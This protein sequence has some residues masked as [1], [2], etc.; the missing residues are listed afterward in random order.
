[1]NTRL[2]LGQF[3]QATEVDARTALQGC[4]T[5][6]KWIE[7]MVNA[8]PFADRAALLEAA[9][10]HWCDLHETDYLQ[11]FEGHPKIGDVGSL[12]SKYAATKALAG[13]EQSGVDSAS[14][15]T[16]QRL[17]RGNIDYEDKFG[18]IFIV[19]ASGKSADEMLGLLEA[20]LPNDRATE[21]HNARVEQA[22]ITALR[23][24]KLVNE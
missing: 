7:R 23:L 20:R 16:L 3:N 22:K 4:C 5:S 18:F 6:Q 8:R 2:T 10:E 13:S 12:R 9:S 19:C 15:E 14:E 11:A 17:S 1:M 21:L 24:R